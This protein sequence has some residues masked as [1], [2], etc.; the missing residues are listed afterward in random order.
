M[1]SWSNPPLCFVLFL[2]IILQEIM[3]RFNNIKVH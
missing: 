2:L 3:S 1:D